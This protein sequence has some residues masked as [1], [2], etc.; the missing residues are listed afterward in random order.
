[1]VEMMNEPQTDLSELRTWL[2]RHAPDH[3]SPEMTDDE[4][5][6]AALQLCGELAASLTKGFDAIAPA[7][8]EAAAAI[9]EFALAYDS[10]TP[11]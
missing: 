6:G 3:Y 5:C 2:A 8:N 9:E 11:R 10:L 7:F 4:V 1:M